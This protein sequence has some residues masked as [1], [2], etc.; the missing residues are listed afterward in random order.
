MGEGQNKMSEV[1]LRTYNDEATEE[2]LARQK[3]EQK[4]SKRSDQKMDS[5]HAEEMPLDKAT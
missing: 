3:F 2:A 1:E 4:H 5:D